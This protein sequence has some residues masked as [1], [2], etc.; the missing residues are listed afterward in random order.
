M[1]E[2]GESSVLAGVI[3]ATRVSVVIPVFNG[4]AHL[5]SLVRRIHDVLAREGV[6]H[7]I[8]LV[9][10][11]SRDHSWERI[12]ALSERNANVRG[13]DLMRNYGQHNALLAGIRAARYPVTITMDDDLQHPPEE[14]PALL[15]KFAEGYDV[16]YG[17]PRE[18][19]HGLWRNLASQVTKLALQSSMGAESARYISALR[20]FRTDLRIAFEQ[21]N[22]PHVSLDVLL[23]WGTTNFGVVRVRHDARAGGKS[24]YTFHK[25][26]T[27]AL[28]MLTGYS[29]RPLQIASFIGFSFTLFGLV[30]LGVVVG[31]FFIQG[32]S[33]PGFPF[34][35]SIIAI[36]SG[37]QLFALGVI[38]EYLA[39]IHFRM[40]ERP[41]YAVRACIER[42][43][44]S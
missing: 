17:A 11:G 12:M 10:D 20:V 22:S 31:R 32:G 42:Q 15:A 39:R 38:G 6:E 9:N 2:Q 29:A 13:I 40:M 34:L 19:Q 37:A 8:L 3:S 27:H 18:E 5:E 4:A 26:L 16:V 7:E 30:V 23:T 14:I 21:Y 25:L 35:A 41:T 44:E 43:K 1:L 24:N 36:F 28:N 33:V